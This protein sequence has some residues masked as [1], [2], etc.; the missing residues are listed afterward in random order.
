MVGPSGPTPDLIHPVVGFRGFKLLE[1]KLHSPWYN[2]VWEQPEAKA[3]CIKRLFGWMGIPA[4]LP[5][6]KQA[7]EE[8][9]APSGDCTCG[10]YAYYE[11][12][13][14]REFAST[15]NAI[16]GVVVLSGAIEVHQEGMRAELI[17]ICALGLPGLRE[18]GDSPGLLR[19][20]V[21]GVAERL[22]VLTVEEE[23]LKGVAE[24]F[25]LPLPVECR[26]AVQKEKEN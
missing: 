6:L 19:A 7:E 2:H 13:S 20:S 12:P 25:G 14:Y 9:D 17:R 26:P 21:K 11:P 5:P 22:G 1:G 10:F 15:R 24:E 16:L 8:H 4:V 23:G 18:S 3:K